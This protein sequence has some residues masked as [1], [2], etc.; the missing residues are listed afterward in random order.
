MLSSVL[1]T[2]LVLA[3]TCLAQ[4]GDGFTQETIAQV[5]ARLQ[6]AIC[7]ITYTSEVSNPQSGEST[8]RG[9][10]ALGLLVSPT[11]LLMAPGHMQVENS[12]PFNITV[13]V[14]QGDEEKEYVAKLLKKPDDVNVCLLQLESETPLRGLPYARFTSGVELE[15]GTPLMVVGVLSEPLD[16]AR[17]IFTC[18]VGAI[19]DKPRTT[20]CIDRAVRFGF[21]GGPVADAQGRVIGV[22]GF[23]LA[24]SEGGDLYVRSGHPLVYQTSL[25]KKYID[26]PPGERIAPSDEEHAW[27]GVF[28]QP[29]SDDLAEYW[30]LKHNGGIVI[31]TLVPGAPAEQVGLRRGDVITNFAGTPIRAKQDREVRGFTKLVREAGIGKAVT[32]KLLRDGKPMEVEV[33]LGS[34]PKSARDAGEYE[35]PLFGITVREITTDVRILLNL[36]DDVQGV[37]VR[38]VKSGGTAAL[39]GLRPGIIVMNLGDFPITSLDDF[40]QAVGKIAAEQPKEVTAFCRAGSATGFFRLEPRW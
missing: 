13:A 36:A 11:G 29:L 30:G 10:N 4:T 9:G 39:A 12:E 25:F 24:V 34:R 16:F 23:D 33:T 31:S 3:Q 26:T 40:R 17:G 27:L 28:T 5:H 22:V 20:Y 1:G 32:I 6:P 35:D 8:K 38:R 37:I 15:V 14:G 21:V 19:L 18:R 2:V 7:V